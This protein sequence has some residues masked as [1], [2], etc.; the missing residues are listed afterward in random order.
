MTTPLLTG[1]ANASVDDYYKYLKANDA[2]GDLCYGTRSGE[3]NKIVR[4]S[5]GG[6]N[7]SKVKMGM[8]TT[9]VHD[10]YMMFLKCN[11]RMSVS[12]TDRDAVA[13]MELILRR[14][15]AAV[16]ETFRKNV[17]GCEKAFMARTA[18]GL[19]IRRGRCIECDYDITHE[20]VIEARHFDD[21]VFN[22]G[23]HDNAPRLKVGKGETY[24]VPY[25]ALC[26]KGLD[27]LYATGMMI[28]SNHS[29]HMSTRNTVSCMGHG[30]ATGTAAALCAARNLGSRELKYSDLRAALIRG[31]V[32][33]EES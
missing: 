30:Q 23:F 9:T 5:G 19:V 8:V 20:D 7:R 10:N 6:P 25:R 14:Q 29:A 17:P 28:T 13:K 2:V 32:Y 21:E 1:L 22:Y 11:Q 3:E 26:V 33:L 24:G 18:P 4:I 15:M 27:N 12:P 16:V 31:K